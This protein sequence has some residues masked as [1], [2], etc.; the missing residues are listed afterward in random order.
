MDLCLAMDR[1]G[2][3]CGRR[4]YK[5]S[6]FYFWRPKPITWIFC[7]QHDDEYRLMLHR[8]KQVR[9]RC[10]AMQWIFKLTS[11]D[12]AQRNC[13]TLRFYEKQLSEAVTTTSQAIELRTLRNS[14]FAA[15]YDEFEHDESVERAREHKD[16]CLF[17]LQYCLAMLEN[18]SRPISIWGSMLTAFQQLIIPLRKH[19]IRSAAN[20]ACK[21]YTLETP[22]QNQTS[23]DLATKYF[24]HLGAGF[25]AAHIAQNMPSEPV[26][27]RIKDPFE[28]TEL[29]KRQTYRK[30]LMTFLYTDPVLMNK[31]SIDI[32]RDT[33][34]AIYR[35]LIYQDKV[36]LSKTR[37]NMTSI[38]TF[39]DD[40]KVTADDLERFWERVYNLNPAIL[41]DALIDLEWKPV[42]SPCKSVLGVNIAVDQ[43]QQPL[44]MC[45]WLVLY[46]IFGNIMNF[47]DLFFLSANADEFL[48]VS[49]LTALRSRHLQNVTICG[50][51]GLN[52]LLLSMRLLDLFVTDWDTVNQREVIVGVMKDG[53]ATRQFARLVSSRAS[54]TIQVKFPNGTIFSN[55]RTLDFLERLATDASRNAGV[56][57]IRVNLDLYPDLKIDSLFHRAGGVFSDGC[58]V[59]IS[60]RFAGPGEEEVWKL[61]VLQALATTKTG[62]SDVCAALDLVNE[63]VLKISIDGFQISNK[64]NA[65]IRGNLEG[66][67]DVVHKLKQ[68]YSL[69]T[70][71]SGNL[72]ELTSLPIRRVRIQPAKDIHEFGTA[73]VYTTTAAVPVP[74]KRPA[75][76]LWQ[77]P[78][79]SHPL[80]P[81]EDSCTDLLSDSL[82]STAESVTPETSCDDQASSDY[83]HRQQSPLEPERDDPA[84]IR[85]SKFKEHFSS[86]MMNLQQGIA[87]DMASY[88]HVN[89]K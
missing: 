37:G 82:E 75:W 38:D 18:E 7:R 88:R 14:R 57:P 52:P 74:K 65:E 26:T 40:A 86:S 36:L 27:N 30:K 48:K 6:V 83:H 42:G 35:R 50:P 21:L 12:L 46:C 39:L 66:D 29:A 45:G 1:N 51:I 44:S 34:Q 84:P 61:E 68:Q 69:A 17:L 49:C 43:R 72:V 70:L 41:R 76:S 19:C 24:G 4:P 87:Q 54:C 64:I 15:A 89:H 32:V 25:Q 71:N 67:G 73:K 11:Y 80:P 55:D 22:D 53:N 13:K 62:H 77:A 47:R 23:P 9:H 56:D 79:H 10:Q 58:E 16:R 63:E 85:L 78:L 2:H 60:P 33:R 3:T 59:Y 28:A 31:L 5:H 81:R 20:S 8:Y